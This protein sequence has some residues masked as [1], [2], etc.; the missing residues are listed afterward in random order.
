MNDKKLNQI[1]EGMRDHYRQLTRESDVLEEL[2]ENSS[3]AEK[4][5]IA[6]IIN[7]FEIRK[8]MAIQTELL[9]VICLE[10]KQI[11]RAITDEIT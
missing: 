4:E 3:E 10:I 6:P 5:K 1:Q 7:N 8:L 9:A 2:G 11:N